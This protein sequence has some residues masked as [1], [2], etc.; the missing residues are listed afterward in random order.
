MS[1]HFPIT[2]QLTEWSEM[3]QDSRKHQL[4]RVS[5]PVIYQSKFS[6]LFG[7]RVGGKDKLRGDL[8]LPPTGVIIM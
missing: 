5:R 7:V 4:G 8:E 1:C 2:S 6:G 3:G